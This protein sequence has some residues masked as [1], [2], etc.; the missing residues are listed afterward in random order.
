MDGET[1]L[2][3]SNLLLLLLLPPL[4]WLAAVVD[5]SADSKIN[6]SNSSNAAEIETGREDC[7]LRELLF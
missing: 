5:P 3:S 4:A 7:F 1:T 6:L 2:S